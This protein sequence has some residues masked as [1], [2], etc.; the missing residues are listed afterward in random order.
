MTSCGMYS[1]QQKRFNVFFG[2]ANEFPPSVMNATQTSAVMMC[3]FF[4]SF[5]PF[6]LGW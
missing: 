4:I 2:A 1:D 3:I 6:C 5:S